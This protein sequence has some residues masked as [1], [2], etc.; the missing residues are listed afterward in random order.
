MQY[1]TAVGRL[2]A[3]RVAVDSHV[4]EQSAD[5]GDETDPVLGLDEQLLLQTGIDQNPSPP[6]CAFPHCRAVR[7]ILD[8]LW[9]HLCGHW[10]VVGLGIERERDSAI[11]DGSEAGFGRPSPP[12]HRQAE[13]RP[14]FP[15]SRPPR[16]ERGSTPY[17]GRHSAD[18]RPGRRAL[19]FPP[20]RRKRLGQPP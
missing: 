20:E 13:P 7:T 17:S 9:E 18:R 2:D 1:R 19:E 4:A 15:P 12:I 3:D 6:A 8:P 5:V 14:K 10:G 16:A 11:G